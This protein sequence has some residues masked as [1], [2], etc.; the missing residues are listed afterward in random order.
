MISTHQRLLAAASLGLLLPLTAC[1]GGSGDE[2]KAAESISAQIQ[3]S[4][5]A[6]LTVSTE[7]ADCIGDGF[8]DE[9]G[10]DQLQEYELLTDD[11]EAADGGDAAMSADDAEKA[12][13]VFQDCTDIK[14]LLTEAM[15]GQGMPPGASD[16]V[17]E[18]LTEDKMNEFLVSLFQEDQEAAAALGQEVV[19]CMAAG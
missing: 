15:E 9:I 2:E 7:E 12:A 10:T 19:Q 5:D 1:A 3:D 18:V 14:G 4:N 13:T 8:V 17:D 6:G 11:L 16:C